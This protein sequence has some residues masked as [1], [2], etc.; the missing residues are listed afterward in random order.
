MLEVDFVD[1]GMHLDRGNW[2]RVPDPAER[3]AAGASASGWVLY[4]SM[5]PLLIGRALLGAGRLDEAI[6]E[7]EHARTSAEDAGA[8]GV[9]AVSAAALEQAR[10]LAGRPPAGLPPPA[11]PNEVEVEAIQTES[12]GL[13]ALTQGRTEE[14]TAAFSLAV[15]RWQRLGFTVW[16][17]RALSLHATAA[18]QAGD[19][20]AAEQLLARAG[21]VL[22]RIK[23]PARSRPGVLAPLDRPTRGR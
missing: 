20:P 14:A 16:L 1:A 19:H 8:V 5:R 4:G 15:E 9:V 12:N 18:R 13:A 22:D 7:L 3:G 11:P 2:R 23:T 6:T 21:D 10:I 17:G